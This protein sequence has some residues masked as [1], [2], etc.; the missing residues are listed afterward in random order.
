MQSGRL[1]RLGSVGFPTTY[2]T[3]L[4]DRTQGDPP[5][6]RSQSG[7]VLVVIDLGLSDR[8]LEGFSLRLRRI[9]VGRL[10]RC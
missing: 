3:T 10:D 5:D 1:E 8:A 4:E 7:C 6:T 2:S 9:R